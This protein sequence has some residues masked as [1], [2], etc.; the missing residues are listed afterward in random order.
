MPR[1]HGRQSW[2]AVIG[3]FGFKQ[4]V[5]GPVFAGRESVELP[6]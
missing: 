4:F 1:V 3:L 6:T 5:A 2:D